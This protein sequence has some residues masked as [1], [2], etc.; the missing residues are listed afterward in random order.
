MEI[1]C[2]SCLRRGEDLV[3]VENLTKQDRTKLAL[4]LKTQYLNELCRGRAV[5]SREKTSGKKERGR[6]TQRE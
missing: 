5:F 3:P 6:G 4:W 1:Q 2:K